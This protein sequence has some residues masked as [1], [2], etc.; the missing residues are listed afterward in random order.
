MGPI[1]TTYISARW[2]LH[3]MVGGKMGNPNK[4]ECLPFLIPLFFPFSVTLA[5]P[6][7]RSSLSLAPPQLC[8]PAAMPGPTTALP[9]MPFLS[10]AFSPSCTAKKP[11]PA[12]R[13]MPVRCSPS[14]HLLGLLSALA[15]SLLHLCVVNKNNLKVLRSRQSNPR[16]S[17]HLRGFV[18]KATSC[19]LAAKGHGN[20]GSLWKMNN[21]VTTTTTKICWGAYQ[22][23]RGVLRG[24]KERAKLSE[25]GRAGRST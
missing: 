16:D 22:G 2:S 9:E 7:R 19:L 12:E 11:S 3:C 1:T 5:L 18:S 14:L 13:A 23:R 4:P 21:S 15:T 20:E 25:P 6:P 24:G 10:Q 17:K 8:L